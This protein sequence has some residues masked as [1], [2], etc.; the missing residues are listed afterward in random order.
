MVRHARRQWPRE[1]C[2]AGGGVPLR[3]AGRWLGGRR[4]EPPLERH[5]ELSDALRRASAVAEV[6]PTLALSSKGFNEKSVV[7]VTEAG[8]NA[9]TSTASRA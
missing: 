9:R 8:V 7:Q 6:R 1:V 4:S 3:G 2:V 5:L